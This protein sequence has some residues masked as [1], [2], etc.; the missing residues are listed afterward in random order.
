MVVETHL[1]HAATVLLEAAIRIA[2]PDTRDWG[3]AMRGELYHIEGAWPAVMW[4][5][6]GAGVLAK[7]AL[8]SFLIPGRRGIV[9]DGGLFTKNTSLRKAA[10]VTGAGFALAALL[11][12]AAPPFRQAFRV[13]MRPWYILFERTSTD[14]QRDF[15]TL[16]KRAAARHDPQ[17]LAFCAVRLYDPRESARL[18]GEAVRLDPSLL[19]V[20]AVVSMRHPELPEVDH[21]V[22]ELERRDPQNGLL[23]LIRAESIDRAHFRHLVW[24]RPTREQDQAWQTAMAAA[25]QSPKFDDYLDRVAE[26]NRRVVPSYGFYDPYEVVDRDRLELPYYAFE[27]CEGY[28]KSILHSGA[29]L[30]ARGDRKAAR[31]K[32]WAVARFGQVIDSQA[33]TAIEHWAGTSLQSMAYTQLQTSYEKEGDWAQAELF[34]YLATKFHPVTGEHPKMA[35]EPAFGLSISS[36][37]AAVVESSALMILVFGLLA[38]VAASILIVDSRRGARPATQRAKPV[39]T[40]VV[41][42]SAVGLLFSSVTLY[43]T[44]RPYWYI[45]QGAIENGGRSQTR[46]LSIFLASTPAPLLLSPRGWLDALLYSGSPSFLFYFWA[47]LTLLGLIGIGLVLLRHFRDRARTKRVSA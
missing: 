15:G 32:Y 33:R 44:Y 31:G 38:L 42:T 23:H 12:F 10:L 16:A 46:D 30:E 9:P 29:D 18:A 47:S 2:P 7:Q 4:A 13:A 8:A 20:Y 35:E 22:G 28:A 43:L 27:N 37:N 19:W 5:L 36:R 39:A 11:F 21:W 14:L 1:R 24:T 45:F 3:Q 25:F 17:G 34:G 40:M 6:G 26:L 41:L